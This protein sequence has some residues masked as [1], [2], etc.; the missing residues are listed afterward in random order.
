M[1]IGIF[2][3]FLLIS[4][5]LHLI[6]FS[7]FGLTKSKDNKLTKYPVLINYIE[8]KDH[9]DFDSQEANNS[10][11]KRAD[12]IISTKFENSPDDRKESKHLDT[13]AEHN[14]KETRQEQGKTSEKFSIKNRIDSIKS[15]S[16]DIAYPDYKVNPKPY[17]PI[18]AQRRG[19]EGEVYLKVYVLDNGQVGELKLEKPSGYT[20]LDRSAVE[21]VKSWVFIPGMKNGIPVAS[22]VT[23][24]IIFQLS[25]I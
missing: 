3:K 24:P 10:T 9:G 8:K 15:I 23:I 12:N 18:I 5:S 22:W 19:Y 13:L 21:A 20:V 25:S 16:T 2:N 11:E 17:Y 6:G 14:K 1:H 7:F 4:V